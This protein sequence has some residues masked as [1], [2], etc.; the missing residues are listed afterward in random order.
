MVECI[1]RLESL[2]ISLSRIELLDLTTPRLSA[3]NIVIESRCGLCFCPGAHRRL[4]EVV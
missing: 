1:Y 3:I 2:S 4:N